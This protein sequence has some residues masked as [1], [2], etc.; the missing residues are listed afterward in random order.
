MLKIVRVM[1]TGRRSSVPS[2]V[3][4]CM[5]SN[6]STVIAELDH[7]LAGERALLD[8]PKPFTR[9][10]I[11]H[12]HDLGGFRVFIRPECGGI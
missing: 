3:A 1:E 9:E 11:N 6:A 8:S 5:N 2:V 12:I 4:F 10:L 7:F